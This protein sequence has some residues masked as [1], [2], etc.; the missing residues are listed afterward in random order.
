MVF[1][2]GFTVCEGALAI[3]K[4]SV[5]SNLTIIPIGEI[6]TLEGL[7]ELI[8]SLSILSNIPAPHNIPADVFFSCCRN[9]HISFGRRVF[10]AVVAPASFPERV[11]RTVCFY[12]ES[13][14]PS[15]ANLIPVPHG[16]GIAIKAVSL[17]FLVVLISA[18]IFGIF[19]KGLIYLLPR[20]IRQ[21]LYFS[22]LLRASGMM[23]R[24]DLVLTDL[25]VYNAVLAEIRVTSA[26]DDLS[27]WKFQ[28]VDGLCVVGFQLLG[29]ISKFLVFFR[30][31]GT[32]W[33]HN[34]FYCAHQ[35][36]CE[37]RCPSHKRAQSQFRHNVLSQIIFSGLQQ[38]DGL[39]DRSIFVRIF[40]HSRHV[41]G[42]QC[43]EMHNDVP[44]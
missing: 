32:V 29:H 33:R 14:R 27:V 4:D 37:I 28:A 26:F 43:F 16:I 1:V 2:Q 42:H 18:I 19:L 39:F 13:H 36:A 25:P 17:F 15:S 10:F 23:E 31:F 9:P 5:C 38:F 20:T 44:F 40:F 34:F 41:H 7:L 3:A 35:L 12:K 24:T 21:V 30:R 22:G 11:F 8:V 6:T